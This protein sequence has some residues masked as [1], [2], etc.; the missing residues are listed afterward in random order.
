MLNLRNKENLPEENHENTSIPR[1]G[2]KR[3]LKAEKFF[4]FTISVTLLF[5]TLACSAQTGAYLF[6]GSETNITLEPGTYI[7]IASLPTV[8]RVV[9]TAASRAASEHKWKPNS[10]SRTLQR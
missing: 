2:E 7:I 4:C 1:T 5:G 8:P 10:P 6:T 9:A 3:Q